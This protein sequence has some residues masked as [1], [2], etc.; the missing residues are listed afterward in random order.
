MSEEVLKEIGFFVLIFVAIFVL[1]LITGGPGRSSSS[2]GVFIKPIS[3]GTQAVIYGPSNI[4]KSSTTT[5][6]V[7]VPGL[8]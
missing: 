4:P 3:P 1:W 7:V 8:K 6:T 2:Q 5:T